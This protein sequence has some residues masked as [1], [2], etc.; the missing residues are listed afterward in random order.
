MAE[1]IQREEKRSAALGR[2]F[3]KEEEERER[4]GAAFSFVPHLS[5]LVSLTITEPYCHCVQCA[6]C[7]LSSGV[8]VV[9]AKLYCVTRRRCNASVSSAGYAKRRST[10]GSLPRKKPRPD[11]TKTWQETPFTQTWFLPRLL[12]Q[13]GGNSM[14]RWML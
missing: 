3:D 10:R 1:Q 11:Y 9:V 7:I 12:A 4:C 14:L 2:Q 6:N 5:A 13:R 8:G